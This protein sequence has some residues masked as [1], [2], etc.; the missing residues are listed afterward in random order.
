MCLEINAQTRS[1][2]AAI[3]RDEQEEKCDERKA[4][5]R[6]LFQSYGTF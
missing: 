5:D 2:A 4:G 6:Y 1:G 3:D